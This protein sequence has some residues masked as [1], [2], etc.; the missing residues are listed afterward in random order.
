MRRDSVFTRSRKVWGSLLLHPDWGVTMVAGDVCRELPVTREPFCSLPALTD[1]RIC[2]FWQLFC[3]WSTHY[4]HAWGGVGWAGWGLAMTGCVLRYPSV[5]L[6]VLLKYG[7]IFEC[8]SHHYKIFWCIKPAIKMKFTPARHPHTASIRWIDTPQMDLM[9]E[10]ITFATAVNARHVFVFVD[11]L[12]LLAG[13]HLP[14][15]NVATM[16]F[17]KKTKQRVIQWL[18]LSQGIFT[19]L[20]SLCHL[21][22]AR[23][24]DPNFKGPIHNR[25]A[26]T[27]SLCLPVL[28]SSVT[29]HIDMTFFPASGAARIS[30]VASSLS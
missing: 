29:A 13:T 21:G 22:E 27:F 23:K 26:V 17:K 6:S 19:I 3:L 2:L 12:L 4:S 8:I 18:I 24:F 16:M 5:V 11:W 10:A 30:S 7:R 25:W 15:W 20:W 28:S 14:F 1:R 9:S